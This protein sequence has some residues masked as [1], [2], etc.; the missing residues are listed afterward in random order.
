MWSLLGAA[1]AGFV[2]FFAVFVWAMAEKFR[3]T[4]FSTITAK[5][6]RIKA[7][8]ESISDQNKMI[9]LKLHPSYY[10]SIRGEVEQWVRENYETW[11]EERPD[12]FTERVNASIPIDMIPDNEVE[13]TPVSSIGEGDEKN[14]SK[15]RQK[16]AEAAGR[17]S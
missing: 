6:F 10:K 1:E 17:Q 3:V 9:I 4:F 2:I 14:S 11:N 13:Q 5:N 12:W 7:F 8:R 15:I 16:I